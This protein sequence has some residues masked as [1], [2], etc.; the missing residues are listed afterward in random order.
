ME[1]CVCVSVN[2]TMS[3]LMGFN[4]GDPFPFCRHSNYLPH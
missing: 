3:S 4:P 2:L 1:I